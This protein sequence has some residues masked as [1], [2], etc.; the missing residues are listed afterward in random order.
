M[1]TGEDVRRARVLLATF[2]DSRDWLETFELET[3]EGNLVIIDDINLT[4]DDDKIRHG[5][6]GDL[7]VP[8]D[9]AVEWMRWLHE[10][11]RAELEKIGV[12]V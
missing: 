12:K 3:N 8:R 11:S 5:F 9:L 7:R 4:A 6:D 1:K 2:D 10:R